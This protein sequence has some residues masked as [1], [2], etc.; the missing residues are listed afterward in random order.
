MSNL[1]IFNSFIS[2]ECL[3]GA[4]EDLPLV[5]G[6][7]ERREWNCLK[8]KHESVGTGLVSGFLEECIHCCFPEA[9]GKDPRNIEKVESDFLRHITFAVFHCPE[10]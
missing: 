10:F 2:L 9:Q 1:H 5:P 7:E 6:L 4:C 3:F 8:T